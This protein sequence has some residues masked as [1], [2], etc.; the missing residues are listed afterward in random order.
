[1]DRRHLPLIG[2]IAV[3][4]GLA[5][6]LL[7]PPQSQPPAAASATAPPSVDAPAAHPE[8]PAPKPHRARVPRPAA[9]P[10]PKPAAAQVTA[11]AVADGPADKRAEPRADA[12]AVRQALKEQMNEVKERL[13]PCVERWTADDPAI[14]G[15]VRLAFQLDADGLSDVWIDE[16]DDVAP[17]LLQCFSDA[18]YDADW[19][20]ISPEPLQVTWPF[21]F[22]GGAS[23]VPAN[24]PM[25]APAPAQAP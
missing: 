6:V 19:S 14:A 21:A 18:V 10:P 8:P 23:S 7:R 25:G 3:V 2:L 17:D 13:R 11:E 20:G 1:M 4:I 16:H 12:E 22:D 15:K 24:N 5:A 9:P